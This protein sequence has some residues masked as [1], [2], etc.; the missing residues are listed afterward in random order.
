MKKADVFIFAFT[1]D[2]FI[3]E[4]ID[5]VAVKVNKSLETAIGVRQT[6]YPLYS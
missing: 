4:I 3:A 5:V 6:R 1:M 2:Q